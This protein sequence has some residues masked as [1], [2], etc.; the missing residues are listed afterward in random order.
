MGRDRQTKQ[1][2]LNSAQRR[3]LK[4]VKKTKTCWLWTGARTTWGYGIFHCPLIPGNT[5]HRY[6][7]FAARKRIPLG[8]HLHH[9]CGK[10]LCV[11]LDHLELVDRQTHGSTE[12][13]KHRK[14]F[15]DTRRRWA[16]SI[17]VSENGRK[18]AIQLAQHY[19]RSITWVFELGINRLHRQVLGRQTR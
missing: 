18:N 6:A 8:H 14:R 11:K 19:A 15:N 4:F 3:F 17:S 13:A 12:L 5:A 10:K 1:A 7:W 9:K 16:T 2:Q